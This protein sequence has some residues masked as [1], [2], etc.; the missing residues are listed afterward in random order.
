MHIDSD[1]D[2]EHNKNLAQVAQRSCGVPSLQVLKARLNGALGR[3][4]WWMAAL[5]MAG[6]GTGWAL[7]SLPTQTI[8]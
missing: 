6:I 3:L 7:G 8:L 2:L 4:I 1:T 5:L